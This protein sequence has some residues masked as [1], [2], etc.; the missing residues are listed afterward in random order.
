MKAEGDQATRDVQRRARL[1]AALAEP[2]RLRIVDRLRLGDAT[3]GELQRL[4]A[5]PSNLLAHHLRVLE[6]DGLVHRHRSQGDGRRCYVQLVPETLTGLCDGPGSTIRASRV[7]FVCTANTA[8]SQLATALWSRASTVPATSAGTHPAARV[9][10]GAV[11]VARR[12]HLPLRQVKPRALDDVLNTDDYIVTVC[13]NAHEELHRAGAVAFRTAHWSVPDPVRLGT[14]AAFDAAYDDLAAR[15]GTLA[16]R[17][18][19]N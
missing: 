16:A 15:V 19:A 10:P 18:T 7:V 8:R 5:M 17:L 2:A 13:D 3:P 11:A 1:H 9:A 4:L 6:A 12:R 14:P